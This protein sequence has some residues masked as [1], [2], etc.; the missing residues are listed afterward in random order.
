MSGRVSDA[1]LVRLMAEAVDENG[2]DVGLERETAAMSPEARRASE[3]SI[4]R[5]VT[6]AQEAIRDGKRR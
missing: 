4:R 1:E 5:W 3:E 6:K 2:V